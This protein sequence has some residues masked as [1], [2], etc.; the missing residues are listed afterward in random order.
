MFDDLVT[1][2]VV[3]GAACLVFVAVLVNRVFAFC[4]S[5]TTVTSMCRSYIH[6]RQSDVRCAY[7]HHG[8]R[9]AASSVYEEIEGLQTGGLHLRKLNVYRILMG[10]PWDFHGIS[11]RFPGIFVG[12]SL[13]PKPWYPCINCSFSKGIYFIFALRSHMGQQHNSSVLSIMYRSP[14]NICVRPKKTILS[15]VDQVVDIGCMC[16]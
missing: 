2:V 14:T 4:V 11:I 15:T 10:C 12:C 6:G 16:V 7:L 8:A 5:M 13:S 1:T 9:G 3:R